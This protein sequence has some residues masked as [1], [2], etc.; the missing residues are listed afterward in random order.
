[1]P[2]DNRQLTIRV[3]AVGP[4][5]AA[6]PCRVAYRLEVLGARAGEG[7]G[8]TLAFYDGASL[9]GE[10]RPG[11]YQVRD[12]DLGCNPEEVR[13]MRLVLTLPAQWSGFAVRE[14]RAGG[15][16]WPFVVDSGDAPGATPAGAPEPQAETSPPGEARDAPQAEAPGGIPA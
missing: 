2:P 14:A 3:R 11:A 5:P 9:D 4:A 7:V 13:S 16:A 10:A 1:M 15:W 6:R 12:F 8:L